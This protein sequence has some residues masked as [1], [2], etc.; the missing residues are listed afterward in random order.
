MND[1]EHTTNQHQGPATAS[2]A[3]DGAETQ[4]V[5]QAMHRLRAILSQLGTLSTSVKTWSDATLDLFLLE[6]KV[7]VEAA[8]QIVLCSIIFTLLSVLFIFSFCLT[9]GVVTYSLTANVL[10]G[11]GVFIVS[12]GLALVGVAWWQLRL[13]RFLGFKNTTVQLQEGWDV[14][15]NKTQSG[16]ANQ[17]DRG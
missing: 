15:S 1:S 5:E 13:T 7:N 8:R 4:Q 10:F 9:A 17:K 11:A 14:L 12:L 6:V 16:D 2:R 3:P